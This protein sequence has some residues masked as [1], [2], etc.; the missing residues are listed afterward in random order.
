MKQQIE[1]PNCKKK[2]LVCPHII[3]LGR[4]YCGAKCYHEARY[5][6]NNIKCKNCGG[7]FHAVRKNKEKFCSR[8]C[9]NEWK[10]ASSIGNKINKGGYIYVFMPNHPFANGNGHVAEHRLIME[11]EIGRH[12]KPEEIVHHTNH[13]RNDNRLENL[14]MMSTETHMSLHRKGKRASAETRKKLSKSIKRARKNKFWS[15]RKKKVI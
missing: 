7:I 1:C 3:R 14:M 13:V 12:L 15:S 11:K 10:T 8:K 9:V 4:K 6:E 2:F 5:K